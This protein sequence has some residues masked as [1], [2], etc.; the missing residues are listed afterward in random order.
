MSAL[1]SELLSKT[2]KRKT[3]ADAGAELNK[4]RGLGS[5]EYWDDKYKQQKGVP[6]LGASP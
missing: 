6:S 3:E 5:K 4:Y 1:L 2:T